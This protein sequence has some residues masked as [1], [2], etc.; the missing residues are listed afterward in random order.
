MTFGLPFAPP[1][2]PARLCAVTTQVRPHLRRRLALMGVIAALAV[3]GLSACSSFDNP[4]DRQN[5]IAEGGYDLDSTVRINAAR[6]VS[7]ERGSGIFIATFD[8]NPTIDAATDGSQRPSFTGLSAAQDSQHQVT[9]SGP[10]HV[11]VGDT[12]SVNMADPSIGGIKVTGDFLPG[13]IVPL[14]LTFTDGDPVTV[15][16][17]VVTRCGPYADVV[18]QG[19]HIKFPQSTQSGDT[20]T[21]PFS[22]NYPPAALPSE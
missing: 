13:D 17:P 19:Q 11:Q 2:A 12:G 7:W 4:T 18:A 8:L 3:P 6:I 10:V 22:C 16:V 15:Q 5:V 21:D 1:T 14:T 20:T 9:A